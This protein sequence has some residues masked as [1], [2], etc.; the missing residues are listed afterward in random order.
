MAGLLSLW[1]SAA[2]TFSSAFVDLQPVAMEVQRF[3]F[4][5]AA[6]SD[7]SRSEPPTAASSESGS[8]P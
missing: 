5:T 2:T 1:W 3:V 4:R 6:E 8:T 7:L